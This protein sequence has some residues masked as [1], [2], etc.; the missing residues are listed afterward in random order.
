MDQTI[1]FFLWPSVVD[2]S[3]RPVAKVLHRG[4]E[5]NE[6]ELRSGYYVYLQANIL[7]KGMNLRI[8]H[9]I[10]GLNGIPAVLQRCLWL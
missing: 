7:G 9:P 3:E 8:P 10:Q 1:M 5:V 6:I 2:R 4:L